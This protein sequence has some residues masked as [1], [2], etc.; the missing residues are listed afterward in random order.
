MTINRL[1][2]LLTGAER[3]F[4]AQLRIAAGTGTAHEFDA[5]LD[6]DRCHGVVEHTHISMH[7]HQRGLH[8]PVQGDAVEDISTSPPDADDASFKR[9]GSCL[10]IQGVAIIFNHG[11]AGIEVTLTNKRFM[12]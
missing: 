9:G 8:T 10:L 12:P 1:A 3:G 11:S 7:G 2:D 4:A 6:F 5:E